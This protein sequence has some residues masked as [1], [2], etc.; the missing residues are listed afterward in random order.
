MNQDSRPETGKRWAL[1]AEGHPSSRR[2]VTALLEKIGY[3]VEP[4]A[5]GVEVL[6]KL[7]ADPQRFGILFMNCRLPELDGPETVKAIRWLERQWGRRVAIVALSAD[8]H[9]RE[10]CLAVGVDAVLTGPVT[11]QGLRQAIAD[12]QTSPLP[13][14]TARPADFGADKPLLDDEVVAALRR[15]SDDNGE[16]FLFE[17]I[18]IFLRDSVGLMERIQSAAQSGNA[19]DVR[20][21]VHALKGSSSTVGAGR[22]AGLCAQLEQRI[23]RGDESNLAGWVRQIA[24]T[25]EQTRSALMAVR[26]A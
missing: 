14:N 13:L 15:L 4:T 11:M 24:E 10:D 1:L 16:D 2:L 5:T 20:A 22:L 21:A 23:D 7:E 12:L 26:Q 8:H 9:D 19:P 18:D 17:V 25:Y 6:K 3:R